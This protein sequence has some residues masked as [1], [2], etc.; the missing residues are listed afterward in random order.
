M[1][2]R[3]ENR[4]Q[5]DP[6]EVEALIT[7]RTKILVVVTPHNPTGAVQSL[8]VLERL[9]AIAL[10]H[11]LIVVS[12]EIYERITY[13]GLTHVSMASFDGLRERTV[14]VNGFSKAYSMTG[15]R[16][17]YVA[18]PTSM[19]Q[20]MNRVHQ[21]N[22]AC[23]C[24]FA[25]EGAVAALRGPQDCV[26]HMVEEFRRRRDLVIGALCEIPRL[27][28]VTP[29]GAFYVFV[30]VTGLG[31]TSETFCTELLERQY[32]SSVPGP[33]FGT[34]GRGYAR[35]SYATSYEALEDAMGR[36]RSF[37]DQVSA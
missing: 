20:A 12:D 30:N 4:Y 16:L 13:D 9:A 17:G 5:I 31:M 10:K 7:P 21:Y 32:V 23:A 3:E 35:F 26:S 22:V 15:W 29:G 28:C 24:S 19:V 8:E 25:Q 1:P 36:L 33:V 2:L 18:A 27:S 6:D 37:C 34:S 11:N 14:L